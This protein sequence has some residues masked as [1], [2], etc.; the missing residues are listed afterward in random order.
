[1]TPAQWH[2]AGPTRP[3]EEFYDTRSDPLNLHNLANDPKHEKT[4]ADM[5]L[6]DV[7][8]KVE[9][10]QGDAHNLKEQFTGYDLVLACNLIDRLYDPSLFISHITPRIN[11][12]GL[13]VLMSPYTWLE[14]FT[15]KD[16]WLGGLKIDGEN[17]ST[18]DGLRARLEPGFRL[19]TEPRDVEFV[20][21][22]TARK[23]QHT[24]SQMT[25]WEKIM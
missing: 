9:F 22:E 6:E 17:V 15:P 3:I 13:L 23:F 5:D 14:D 11:T 21:R 8:D 20:I 4:L 19:F 18:L 2:Y 1:M 25:V 10:R 7:R 12:G 16:K 24:A